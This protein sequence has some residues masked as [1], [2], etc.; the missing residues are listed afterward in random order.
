MTAALLAAAAGCTPQAA[1]LMGLLPDG[2]GSVLLSHLE[3]TDDVNKKRVLEME[4]KKDWN[5]IAKFA[6]A[7]VVSDR[8]NADWWF[9]A[10]YAH[11]QAG[12]PG[13]AVE[14][15]S[16]MTRLV[17]DDPLGWNLLA[18]A[19]RDNKQPARAVSAVNTAHQLRKGTASSYFLLGESY[20][21]LNR[22]LPAAGA[23]REAV[24][25]DGDFAKAWFGLGRASARLGRKEDFERSVKELDRIDPKLAKELRELRPVAR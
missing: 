6:D 10:G 13:R 7:N 14:A 15:F 25:I 17:P 8:N 2:T 1:L 5:G 3:G 20:A 22:D 19:H 9:V 11:G 12:R 18:Q 21:D 23:Y 16:E 4:A 24:Q